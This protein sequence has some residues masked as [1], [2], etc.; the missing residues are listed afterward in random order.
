[1]LDT[2]NYYCMYGKQDMII[3]PYLIELTAKMA[4]AALFTQHA[5]QT[6]NNSEG[7]ILFQMLFQNFRGT[8]ALD[9][10]FG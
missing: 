6:I 9:I 8:N 5:N 4:E 7:A 3:N 1:M 2:I 10:I